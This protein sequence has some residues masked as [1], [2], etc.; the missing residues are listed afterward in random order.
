MSP[1]PGIWFGSQFSALFQ[2]PLSVL[3][4]EMSVARA[5]V[6][7]KV[8]VSPNRPA[9]SELRGERCIVSKVNSPIVDRGQS[10]TFSNRGKHKKCLAAWAWLV[11]GSGMGAAGGLAALA[12]NR[13]GVPPAWEEV[14]RL[15]GGLSRPCQEGPARLGRAVRN[16]EPVPGRGA[17]EAKYL[18]LQLT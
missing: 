1:L 13:I 9:R 15:A 11:H 6:A 14:S 17:R 7:A 16:P 18:H 5:V 4:H 8:R 12:S 2:S 3:V 10:H